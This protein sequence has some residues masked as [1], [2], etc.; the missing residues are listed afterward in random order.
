M[1]P[2]HAAALAANVEA[3]EYLLLIDAPVEAENHNGHTALALMVE[4]LLRE[5]RLPMAKR[6]LSHGANVNSLAGQNGAP[7]R[8]C[9]EP[10]TRGTASRVFARS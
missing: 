10:Q 7:S 1:T 3:V 6:L 5:F 4:S 2:L 8:C 9:K